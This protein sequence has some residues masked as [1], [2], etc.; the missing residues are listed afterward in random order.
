MYVALNDSNKAKWRVARKAQGCILAGYS[1]FDAK[2][3]ERRFIFHN[4]IK[5]STYTYST[6]DWSVKRHYKLH[7]LKHI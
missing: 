5:Y 2:E 3:R 7:I 6:V 1:F 4:T